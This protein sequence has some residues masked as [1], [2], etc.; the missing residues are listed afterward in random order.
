MTEEPVDYQYNIKKRYLNSGRN[1]ISDFELLVMLFNSIPQAK[2]KQMAKELFNHYGSLR[3]IINQP[4]DEL[5][6]VLE[7]DSALLIKILKDCM[8]S[9]F[10]PEIGEKIVLSSPEAVSD[11]LLK[12]LE[13]ELSGYSREYFMVLCLNASN[14]LIYKE[15]LFK[16]TI[17]QTAV[18]PR[19]ILKLALI[20]NASGLICC[21]NHPSLS[22]FPSDED[23]ILTKKLEDMSSFFGIRM[24][25]NLIVGNGV[26]SI[27]ANRI[28]S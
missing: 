21:H 7:D 1:G 15:I 25:D 28:V 22:P 20:N 14:E 9:Y 19:E 2:S 4:I 13:T 24:H 27:K 17:D 10:E 11:Y 16:G 5:S 12:Y 26:F 8:I 6:K 23:R 18:Y 3:Q